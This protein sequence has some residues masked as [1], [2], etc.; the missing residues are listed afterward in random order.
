MTLGPLVALMPVFERARGAVANALELYGRVPLFYYVLHIPL[1]HVAAIVVSLVRT[2][3]ITPWLF[4]NHP[5]EPP[6]QPP[7]YRWS[8]VL[9]YLVT[10]ICVLALYGACRWW[11]ERKQAASGRL[12]GPIGAA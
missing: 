8:L 1:I 7:G 3:T 4:A 6:D 2:G 12:A 5:M 9:L 11:V 10:A